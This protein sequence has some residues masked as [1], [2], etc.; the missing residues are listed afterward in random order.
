MDRQFTK[1][2]DGIHRVEYAS[3]SDI[4][5]V[6]TAEGEGNHAGNIDTIDQRNRRH[7]AEDG[8]GYFNGYSLESIIAALD[9]PPQELVLAVER[10]KDQIETKVVA[11]T[12]RRR[13]TVRRLELGDELD[14]IAW[15]SRSPEGWSET[16]YQTERKHV[17]RIAVNLS[18]HCRRTPQQLL[19]RGA[20][21]A[22]LADVLT[23]QGYS[24][25]IVAFQSGSGLSSGQG[26][27]VSSTIVKRADAPL[28]IGAVAL[29]LSEIAFFRIVTMSA[30]ARLCTSKLT[31]GWGHVEPL[32]DQ[33]RKQFDIILDSD[34][35]TEAAAIAVVSR[36]AT[37]ITK[38][39]N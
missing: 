2:S 13:R 22:A 20:A 32:P 27:A 39:R 5:A 6:A 14:P 31:G 21:A 36:Y 4:V 11:P 3:V 9:N 28:D 33:D 38:A 26:S 1:D 16:R 34:I 30:D 35:L 18:V 15:V 19:Y 24:V 8:D 7:A 25:E 37:G 10:I 23:V 29:A 12:G 17:A